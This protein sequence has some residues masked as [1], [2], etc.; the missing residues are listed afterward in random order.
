[1]HLLLVLSKETKDGGK[2]NKILKNIGIVCLFVCL[3]VCADF[4]RKQ[5]TFRTP[6]NAHTAEEMVPRVY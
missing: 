5:K 6:K 1:M 3:I 2:C 4:R